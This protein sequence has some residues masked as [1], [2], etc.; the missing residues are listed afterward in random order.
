[1]LCLDFLL[2]ARR[3]RVESE[4]FDQLPSQL[5]ALFLPIVQ[6]SIIAQAARRHL[7][8]DP[9]EFERNFFDNW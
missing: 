4:H 2:L 1:V 5:R 6:R 7:G 9:L 3:Q 8:G